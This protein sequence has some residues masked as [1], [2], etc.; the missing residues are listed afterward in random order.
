MT[1]TY[2]TDAQVKLR[3][4]LVV[5]ALIAATPSGGTAPTLDDYRVEAQRQ[6]LLALRAKGIESTDITR[7]DDLREPEVCLTAA[8]VFE[9]ACQLRARGQQGITPDLYAS[10]AEFWR[11]LYRDAI[12][13]AAPVDGIKSEGPTFEWLRG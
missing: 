10:Q 9:A 8:L 7:E 6:L 5:P 4:P 3:A 1:T 11:A 12:D 2:A 13:A